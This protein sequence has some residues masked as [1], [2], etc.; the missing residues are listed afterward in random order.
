M[1]IE[2]HPCKGCGGEHFELTVKK[3][4]ELVIDDEPG[5]ARIDYQGAT[6][7]DV[8]CSTCGRV[9]ITPEQLTEEE[10]GFLLEGKEVTA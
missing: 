10:K 9:A 3:H 7:G 4:H 5:R 2:L 8:A 1:L 6:A